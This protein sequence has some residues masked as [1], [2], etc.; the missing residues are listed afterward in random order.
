MIHL[1]DLRVPKKGKKENSTQSDAK[2]S[3]V[4]DVERSTISDVPGLLEPT[5]PAKVEAP[6]EHAVIN[7]FDKEKPTTETEHEIP[8]LET[9]TSELVKAEETGRATEHAMAKGA[10][11]EKPESDI[12]S[13]VT[14]SETTT[15]ESFKAEEPQPV[16]VKNSAPTTSSEAANGHQD[17]PNVGSVANWQTYA[18]KPSGFQV[19]LYPFATKVS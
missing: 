17:V 11:E 19:V 18:G 1:D 6:V 3:E 10:G 9:A 14:K 5:E 12:K 8:S 16:I 13:E 4:S 7:G 2:Q 15:M